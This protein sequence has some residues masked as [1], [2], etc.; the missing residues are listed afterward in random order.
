MSLNLYKVVLNHETVS[1]RH[2]LVALECLL[3]Q[4]V[5]DASSDSQT[6]GFLNAKVRYL[7]SRNLLGVVR[8]LLSK[9]SIL[10]WPSVLFFS[11][12]MVAVE[13]RKRSGAC[14]VH[15]LRRD[16]LGPEPTRNVCI[17]GKDQ[18]G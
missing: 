6:G 10:Y 5:D 11:P 8:R 9:L 3:Q 14:L 18:C 15:M 12:V 17:I 1:T 13:Q 7:G 2:C 16:M 4:L